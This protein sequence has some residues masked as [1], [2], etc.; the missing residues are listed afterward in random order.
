MTQEQ[1]KYIT[2]VVHTAKYRTLPTLKFQ[3]RNPWQKKDD[4]KLHAFIPGIIQK[5]FV[6]EGEDVEKGQTLL[7]LDAMKMYNKLIAPYDGKVKKIYVIEGERVMKQH[8]LIDIEAKE[9]IS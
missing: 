3:R 1:E 2:F 9:E 4:S 5:I 7:I 6:S 8:L